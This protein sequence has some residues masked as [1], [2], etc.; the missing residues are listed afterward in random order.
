MLIISRFSGKA[1]FCVSCEIF[2]LHYMLNSKIYHNNELLNLK[3]TKDLIPYYPYLIGSSC[4]DKDR[5]VVY[6][7]SID[8]ITMHEI[9]MLDFYL[10][11][12]KKAYRRCKRKHEEFNIE[13]VYSKE[14]CL[15]GEQ[16]ELKPLVERVAK[17][18]NKATYDGIYLRT[19]E[20]YRQEW[21]EELLKYG[22][23]EKWIEN[24]IYKG[25]KE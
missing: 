21:R 15:F 20:R 8:Y 10:E 23:D 5:A 3:E 2:G 19:A 25:R 4:G 14:F 7:S 17:L 1:D 9:E 18:G 11:R 13:E 22:Y 12:V 16:P 24:W 6:L